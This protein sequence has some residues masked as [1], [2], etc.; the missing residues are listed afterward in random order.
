MV[1]KG[2]EIL[3]CRDREVSVREMEEKGTGSVRI[4]G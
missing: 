1:K 2:N 3:L 4:L